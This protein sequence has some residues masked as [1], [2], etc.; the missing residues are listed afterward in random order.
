MPTFT[1]FGKKGGGKTYYALINYILRELAYGDRCVCTTVAL[2]LPELSAYLAKKYPS[3]DIDVNKRVRILTRDEGRRFWLHRQPGVDLEDVTDQEYDNGKNPDYSSVAHL[4]GVLYVIDEIHI[5]FDARNWAKIGRGLTYYNSQERKLLDDQ[6]FITQFLDLVDKRVKNFS[7][8]WIVCRNFRYEKFLTF[9]SKGSSMQALHFPFPPTGRVG[10]VADEKHRYKV[11]PD[12]ADCYDTSVGVGF[13]GAGKA[14]TVQKKKA[15]PWWVIFAAAPALWFVLSKGIDRATSLVGGTD[16][17]KAIARAANLEKSPV[18]EGPSVVSVDGRRV[19]FARDEPPL[20]PVKKR[21]DV[22]V[23]AKGW[24][25]RKSEIRGREGVLVPLSDGRVLSEPDYSQPRE[26]W[27]PESVTEVTRS[28]VRTASGGVYWFLTPKTE[29][30]TVTESARVVPGTAEP[31]VVEYKGEAVVPQNGEID[32][33]PSRA[34]NWGQSAPKASG[35][36]EKGGF[37][38]GPVRADVRR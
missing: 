38:P 16:G 17:G 19:D 35:R 7:Q 12:I 23:Y 37:Q 29:R 18:S 24:V 2:K 5:D 36:A 11:N 20:V 10:E 14:D 26:R 22:E 15:L 9:L 8:E 28:F 4:G 6:V 13:R 32:A 25:V 3:R 27:H 31:V 30:M 1:I 34:V 33:G 21:A